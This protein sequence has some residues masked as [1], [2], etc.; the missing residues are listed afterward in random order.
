M[1]HTPDLGMD[2]AGDGELSW[3]PPILRENIIAKLCTLEKALLGGGVDFMSAI[4][5][6]KIH[7]LNLFIF[8]I[9]KENDIDSKDLYAQKSF[10]FF[11]LVPTL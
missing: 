7:L 10:M 1:R 3:I 6:Y 9:E 5:S 8:D 2:P 4:I 11:S